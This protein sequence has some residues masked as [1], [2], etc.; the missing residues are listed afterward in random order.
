MINVELD[1]LTELLL[2]YFMQEYLKGPDVRIFTAE[3]I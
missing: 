1:Y 3:D 2:A